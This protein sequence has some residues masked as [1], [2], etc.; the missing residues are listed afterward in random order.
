MPDVRT[1]IG[2]GGR[3]VIPT[4]Y[5][6]KIGVSVGDEVLLVL[7]EGGLRLLTP[8]EAVKRA[9]VLVRKY[10]PADASLEKELIEERR[11]ENERE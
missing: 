8:R 10:V 11:K 2:R 4:R 7:E 6:K 5:R 1:R 3:I 9:Q